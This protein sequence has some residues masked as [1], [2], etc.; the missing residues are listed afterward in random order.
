MNTTEIGFFTAQP[1]MGGVDEMG[2]FTP[3]HLVWLTYSLAL[4]IVLVRVYAH[5]R[6]GTELG[7]PRRTMM[8]IVATVPP[9]LLISQD[10]IMISAGMFNPNWWPLHACN[11]CEYLGL[12]YALRPN[13]FSGEVLFTLGIGGAAAA[14][15]FPNWYYCP[16]WSWPVLCGFTEHSLIITFIAMQMHA[17]DFVPRLRDI[18]MPALFVGIYAPAAYAFNARFGTNFAF[19]TTPSPGSPLETMAGV[20]GIPGYIIPYTLTVFAIWTVMYVFWGAWMR[21]SRQKDAVH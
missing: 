14:L 8:L 13:R 21:R 11:L 12:V 3:A 19:V 17:R 5:Q 1:Y 16:A 7:S 10:C 15:L 18:W 4:I 2:I 9:V 20:F 6:P